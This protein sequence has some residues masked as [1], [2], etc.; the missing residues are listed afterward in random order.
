MQ[1]LF[2]VSV[3]PLLLS[4]VYQC[5]WKAVWLIIDE[6]PTKGLKASM[7]NSL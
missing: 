2:T 4:V 5:I 7:N 6:F 1:T 3:E